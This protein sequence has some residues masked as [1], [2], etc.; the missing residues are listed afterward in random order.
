MRMCLLLALSLLGSVCAADVYWIA[1]GSA[2]SWHNPAAWSTGMVPGPSDKAI[3]YSGGDADCLIDQVTTVNRLQ[4]KT[5]YVGQLSSSADLTVTNDMQCA[6]RQDFDASG[7]IQASDLIMNAGELISNAGLDIDLITLQAGTVLR[8]NGA[9]VSHAIQNNGG[10][11]VINGGTFDLYGAYNDIFVGAVPVIDVQSG[12]L[13]FADAST[14]SAFSFILLGEI[15]VNGSATWTSPA[16]NCRFSDSNGLAITSMNPGDDLYVTLVDHNKN[17]D[18]GLAE[19]VHLTMSTSSGDLEALTLTETGINTGVFRNSLAL[20]T[21]HGVVS[22]NNGTLEFETHSQVTATYQD[23][24]D[25]CVVK[26]FPF[27]FANVSLSTTSVT[28]GQ[29]FVVTVNLSEPATQDV[30]VNIDLAAQLQA[31]ISGLTQVAIPLGATSGQTTLT[32]IDDALVETNTS[33]AITLLAA[34]GIILGDPT[35]ATLTI[36]DDDVIVLPTAL[37]VWVGGQTNPTA[38]HVGDSITIDVFGGQPAYTI[39]GSG[40]AVHADQIRLGMDI[41]GDGHTEPAQLF[42]FTPLQAGLLSFTVTDQAGT[43]AKM[44]VSVAALPTMTLPPLSVP[45]SRPNT[46]VYTSLAATSPQGVQ[47]LIAFSNQYNDSIFKAG[48]WDPLTQAFVQMPTMPAHGIVPHSGVF[49]A[50]RTALD[51]D[52]SGTPTPLSHRIMLQ[53]QWNFIGIPLLSD[54]SE[55]IDWS[56]VPAYLVNGDKLSDQDKKKALGETLRT[57]DGGSYEYASQLVVGSGYWIFNGILPE[58]PIYIELTQEAA[59]T[60]KI[61]ASMNHRS[62]PLDPPMLQS[63][64]SPTSSSNSGGGCGS[65]LA[66]LIPLLLMIACVQ[67]RSRRK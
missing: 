36:V 38:I 2:T 8:S 60:N 3:F 54:G 23:G 45:I 5:S 21:T 11:I 56:Q 58:Q 33:G 29:L 61:A 7:S 57:W 51:V 41:N 32:V 19:T 42:E 44:D 30:T 6:L 47:K 64:T 1:N 67:A 28:E 40:F 59:Q 53:P 66:W 9:T 14:I 17:T 43:V 31:Q 46:T 12:T 25:Q 22:D 18:G 62:A 48:L 55:F 37:Q 10:Q 34:A 50:T 35:Y 63:M 20:P 13:N 4:V 39:S 65:G 27:P 16:F 49:V 52:F 26:R 15:H 24:T